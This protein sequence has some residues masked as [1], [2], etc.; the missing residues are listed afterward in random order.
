MRQE[1]KNS[2]NALADDIDTESRLRLIVN[3]TPALIYSAR[4]DGYID[5]LNQ[6]CLEFVGLS[7]EEISGWG[8]TKTVHPDDLEGV[9]AKWRAALETGEPF[10]A[11]WRVR[12]ADGNYRW[13]LHRYAALVDDRKNIVRW[14][15]SSTDIDD[16][17]RAEA[18]LLQTTDEL[19]R[20][21]FYLAEGQ[22]LAHIGSWSFTPDGNREYWSAEWF[23]I[24]GWDPARGV[25]PIP[26]YL[27]LVHPDDR[28]RVR[29]VIERMIEKG[30]GCDERY[31]ILHPQRGVRWIRG[32]GMPVFENGVLTRFAGT[33]MDITEE[34]TLTQELKR[35]EAYL[36]EAQSMSHTGSF[37]WV[38]ST[39]EIFWSE[40]TFR[41][42]EYDPATKP[43]VELVLQRT[44]PE[45]KD[46]VRQVI[47]RSAREGN[48]FDLE[49]RLLMPDKSIKYLHVIAHLRTNNS[50][51]L[52]FIGAVRDVTAAKM[53]QQKLKQ[54]EA[55]L[56]QLI[57][58]VPEHVLVMKP[59]G[60]RICGNQA[61]L[62]YFGIS[63]QEVQ[64]DDF[65]TRVVHPDDVANGA[66]RDL[67]RAVARGAAWEAELR[68]RRDDGEHRWFLIRSNP[69]H[70]EHGNIIRR[71]A[72]ATDIDDRKRA[73]ERVQ[74]E[75][76]ALREEIDKAS[77]FEEIVGSSAALK[78]V[79]SRVSK[80]APTDATVLLTGETG[81]GKELIARAIHKR[82]QR[83][84]KAFVTVNCAAIPPA[85]I[86]SELFGHEKGA[87][88]GALQRRLGRFELAEGGTIFLDEIGELPPETQNTLLRVL[89]EREFER[90]GGNQ[91]IRADVRVIAA[92]NRDLEAAMING[93]FRSDLFYRLQ[94]FPIEVRPLRER[95]E[96]IP[97]LVEY[98]ID[99]YASKMGKKIRGIK[100][101]SLEL[102]R[103]YFWPGNIR[104]LQNVVERALIVA[105]TEVLSIDES[106]L[107]SESA[108]AAP[109]SGGLSKIPRDQEKKI[110]EAALAETR[111][112]VSGPSGAAT[113]LRIPSTTL[114]SRIRSLKINKHRFKS[115]E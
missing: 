25:P 105:E 80:V 10:M 45:D 70:D 63:L 15:G 50:E 96:D 11:E 1:R 60:T 26:D 83:A 17:K 51:D 27:N 3:R 36:A 75:N 21:E 12:R 76:V 85:L 65:Y 7:F 53:A 97:L 93:T 113:K 23:D 99:R 38:V 56:R 77:M 84:T 32:V 95:K 14:F 41:I 42:F 44:H 20:S 81:T 37:G 66:L 31:R 90:V 29:S 88:T 46:F 107:S 47:D 33:S 87:F 5:F 58:F 78:D 19:R 52:E 49:H 24:L 39:G 34:E 82:S 111:G 101:K 98:F 18:V 86:G 57:N 68:L 102:L 69:L 59:D 91:T 112:R 8:W 115:L 67:E 55:E 61:M 114:E 106:W 62:D 4:P 28:E 35:S 73:E 72:T 48:D 104:E 6:H 13:T 110:I 79:L 92:T 71:Y 22:R 30:E 40:E 89:Q 103:S 2:T 43:T 109:V 9:L 100:Q 54:D 74:K 16:Q 108:A 64:A 94:V